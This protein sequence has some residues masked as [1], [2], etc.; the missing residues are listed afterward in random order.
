MKFQLK[1]R[2]SAGTSCSSA[3]TL[4]CSHAVLLAYLLRVEI[5]EEKLL[6]EAMEWMEAMEE[7]FT[8]CLMV[9]FH[10]VPKLPA[11]KSFLMSSVVGMRMAAIRFLVK[12]FC[13]ADALG[14]GLL[15]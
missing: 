13:I 5:T 2:A 7:L 8:W 14:L 4:F 1:L 3:R 11:S 6:Q 9:F 15:S 10:F 12:S